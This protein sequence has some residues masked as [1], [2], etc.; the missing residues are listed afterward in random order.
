L[1]LLIRVHPAEIRGTLP[2]RQPIIPEI[3][4]AFPTLPANVFLIAPESQVSTYAV[5]ARCNAV[6]IYGTKTGVEL[7]SMGIPTIA[8]GEAWIRNKGITLDAN[9]AEE[10]FRLLDRL[11]ISERL[12]PQ[13]LERARKYAYH[14]FFRRMIPL[15]LLHPATDRQSFTPYQLEITNIDQ[16]RPGKDLGLDVICNGILEGREF[17]YP[18]EQILTRD[19]RRRRA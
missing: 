11:P 16:L 15:T 18:A 7:T 19:A 9:S 12:R 6:V 4:R 10:Y 17:I 8:A 2:S 5:M 1:Q 14:F 13:I 3:E